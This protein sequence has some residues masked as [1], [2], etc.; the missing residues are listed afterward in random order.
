MRRCGV[1]F[2]NGTSNT[3]RYTGL[4][5]GIVRG[6]SETDGTHSERR[7]RSRDGAGGSDGSGD[8][9]GDGDNEEYDKEPEGWAR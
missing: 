8:G 1:V 5:V 9:N 3:E 6:V 2:F 7:Q 4:P